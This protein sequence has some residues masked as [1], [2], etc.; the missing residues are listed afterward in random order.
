MNAIP[1]QYVGLRSEYQTIITTERSTESGKNFTLIVVSKQD[2][3]Q[4]KGNPPH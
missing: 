2:E 4:R 1:M 3:E